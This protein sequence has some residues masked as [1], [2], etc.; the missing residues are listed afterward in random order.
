MKSAIKA[1]FE[2]AGGQITKFNIDVTILVATMAE[3]V[4]DYI[5]E[6]NLKLAFE[7]S[8]VTGNPAD[9]RL[10]L[11]AS[12]KVRSYSEK[13][14][15]GGLMEVLGQDHFL[16]QV[17]LATGTEKELRAVAQELEKKGYLRSND[18]IKIY[19][20]LEDPV[21]LYRFGKKVANSYFTAKKKEKKT[22]VFNGGTSSIPQHALEILA[23]AKKLGAKDVNRELICFGDKLCA[24]DGGFKVVVHSSSRE[25]EV[26]E[27]IRA[28]E[29]AG[30]LTAL[31][32]AAE[33][34]L[35]VG[36][37]HGAARCFS[38]VGDDNRV[39]ELV[40]QLA[41]IGELLEAVTLRATLIKEPITVQELGRLVGTTAEFAKAKV[42]QTISAYLDARGKDEPFPTSH[43]FWHYSDSNADEWNEYLY[44]VHSMASRTNTY[45]CR[46][47]PSIAKEL[48]ATSNAPV[49]TQIHLALQKHLLVGYM[50]SAVTMETD[51]RC[52]SRER[53][54]VHAFDA[55]LRTFEYGVNGGGYN[56]F[57]GLNFKTD[58]DMS[59][60]L[61]V[62]LKFQKQEITVAGKTGGGSF[63]HNSQSHNFLREKSPELQGKVREVYQKLTGDI[64]S[65]LTQL[66]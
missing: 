11:E 12:R 25:E 23:V 8:K 55:A 17:L 10:V 32:K 5:A 43:T 41:K 15:V 31:T 37:L 57:D 9:Q 39:M 6:G 48:Y 16:F 2:Q 36:N 61:K 38:K 13:V 34:Y 33:G 64:R 27:A 65:L 24:V 29:I 7:A 51:G 56:P 3:L 66:K 53:K 18:V 60:L 58:P 14:G 45:F 35:A 42:V 1:L 63:E 50:L 46:P 47:F 44:T 54:Y 22:H 62:L 28:Y 21:A 59:A 4:R 49:M 19:T 52:P 20:Q 30:T 26:P 40:H